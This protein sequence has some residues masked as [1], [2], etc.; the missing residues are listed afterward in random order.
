M[1]S[2]MTP[3]QIYETYSKYLEKRGIPGLNAKEE[4][5]KFI[6]EEYLGDIGNGIKI[7]LASS[8]F[9]KEITSTILWLNT[10]KMAIKCFR[11]K[12]YKLEEK[13]LL[14][15][16]QV[17]PLPEAEE[18]QVKI[19]LK[20]EQQKSIK[21]SEKDYTRYDLYMGDVKL[22]NL[23][24]RN[25]VLQVVTRIVKRN[26]SPEDI[27]QKIEWRKIWFAVDGEILSEDEFLDNA[28]KI[29]PH[30]DKKRYFTKDEE[31]ITFGGKTYALS[32][33]WGK[34]TLEAID[35]IFKEFNITDIRYEENR[36]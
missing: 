8:E 3:D 5:N 36:S 25:L 26:I 28:F 24:K 11:L 22:S 33:Q 2:S 18:Y 23:A 21:E 4:I 35:I 10:F 9:D 32:N 13:I 1:I 19:S 7:I 27:A 20:S 16:Q 12:P 6:L 17:I 30:F 15:V 29:N 34:R 14:E 31:I